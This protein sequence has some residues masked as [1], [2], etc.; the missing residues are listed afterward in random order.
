M[1]VVL[2]P[3]ACCFRVHCVSCFRVLSVCC[4]GSFAVVAVGFLISAV[5]E[6]DPSCMLC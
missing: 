3:Y 2:G 5:S 4:F 1:Y 6:K